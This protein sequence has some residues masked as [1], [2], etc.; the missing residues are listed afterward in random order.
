VSEF[1]A[2]LLR[3]NL[4]VPCVITG[5]TPSFPI[6]AK[7]KDVECSPGTCV[8]WD[9]GYQKNMPDLDYLPPRWCSRASRANPAGNR[10]C[11]D[12]GHKSIAS[13]N[14]HPRVV[15][16]EIPDAKF[17]GHSEEHL[18]VES[19]LAAKM[20]VGDPVYGIPWHICPTVALHS[21]AM[22]IEDGRACSRW[23]VVGRDRRISV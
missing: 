13:E 2:Q 19:K 8:F 10:I 14:P 16:P 5:G 3:E 15:F 18:V 21:E 22:A 11:L 12:L 17:I 4:P 6:H 23:K 7:R 9:A 1:K 20:R